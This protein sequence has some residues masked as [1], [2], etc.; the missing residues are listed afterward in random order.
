MQRQSLGSPNLKLISS[1]AGGGAG[2]GGILSTPNMIT[3][4][5]RR[6]SLSSSSSLD[7]G[8]DKSLKPRRFSLF[9]PSTTAATKPENLIHLIPILTLVCFLVL[10]LSSHNPSQSDLAQFH[11]FTLPSK[12]LDSVEISV[13]GGGFAE[14]ERSQIL[15]IKS[16][17]N[18]Q[19][20]TNISPKSKFP[21]RVADF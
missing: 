17:R 10:Y 1:H 2:A 12:H 8:D 7:D 4:E 5:H 6:D 3:V 9:Q 16:I 19:E 14:L 20:S 11:G 13:D 21:R 18:L 15:R